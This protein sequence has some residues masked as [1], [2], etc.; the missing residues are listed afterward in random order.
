MLCTRKTQY[1]VH[2]LHSKQQSPEGG[3]LNGK[4]CSHILCHLDVL[5]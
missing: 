4:S 3:R 5:A 1:A 2:E